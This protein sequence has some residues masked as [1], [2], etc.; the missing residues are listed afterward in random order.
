MRL[1]ARSDGQPVPVLDGVS[2]SYPLSQRAFDLALVVLVLP[3]AALVG[4]LVAVAVAL[5]SPGPILFRSVRVGRNGRRF[6]MVKFRTMR[7]MAAGPSISSQRDGRYTPIGRLLAAA[8][9]DELPQLWHVLR[10]QMRLVGPRPEL[11]Q[12]V[13]EHADSYRR[14]LAVPPGITGPTQLVFADEGRVLAMCADPERTYTQDLLPQKVTL[15]LD[16]VAAG[17]RLTD[18]KVLARSWLVPVRQLALALGESS[19][20]SRRRAAVVLLRTLTL[21]ATVVC[22]VAIFAVESASAF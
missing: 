14:I 22:M 12:F 17:S 3:A 9:V 1:T 13:L 4:A 10:G 15:D 20:R 2:T 11:S 16:Y 8:R 5:D 18:L 19:Q 7:H 6:R 21:V